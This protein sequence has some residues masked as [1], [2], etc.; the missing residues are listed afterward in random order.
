M[1]AVSPF[2]LIPYAQQ[3]SNKEHQGSR[4]VNSLLAFRLGVTLRIKEIKKL[5]V[6]CTNCNT[7]FSVIFYEE[8]P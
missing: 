6:L 1:M 3:F 4:T 2:G 5:G 7:L 8:Y